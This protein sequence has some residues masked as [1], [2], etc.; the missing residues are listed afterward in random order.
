MPIVLASFAV[1]LFDTTADA[2]AVA[3]T[4]AQ[5]RKRALLVRG[6]A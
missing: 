1:A 3:L 4:H 5:L 6:A 2:L